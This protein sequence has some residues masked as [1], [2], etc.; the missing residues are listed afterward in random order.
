[1]AFRLTLT[2]R[3]E[4]PVRMLF[5]Q[6]HVTVG[7]APSNDVVVRDPKVSKAHAVIEQMPTGHHQLHDRD[8]KN[9]TFVEDEQ[10]GP[11]A[12]VVLS[13]GASVHMG[14]SMLSYMPL[15]PV[16]AATRNTEAA[17]HSDAEDASATER[18]PDDPKALF[19]VIERSLV[20][21]A[22]HIS[23][24]NSGNRDTSHDRHDEIKKRIA[25]FPESATDALVT[26]ARLSEDGM[27]EIDNVSSRSEAWGAL[28]A[29]LRDILALPAA[30]WVHLD[31]VPPAAERPLLEE[32]T[33]AEVEA[34][35]QANDESASLDRLCT[36][37]QHV[38]AHHRA[39]L[40]SYQSSI[41][42]G[43]KALL[44]HIS[45]HESLPDPSKTGVFTR[46]FGGGDTGVS[47]ER[48]ERRWRKLYHSDWED[49]E[50]KLFR[51]ALLEAYQEHMHASVPARLMP[52][53][54]EQADHSIPR[55]GEPT[56]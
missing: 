40:Q 22:S 46:V 3:D 4:P 20:R 29:T 6:D 43:G 8:S 19:D 1:M 13:P 7:R 15:I 37:L 26:L 44:R 55:P 17:P 39:M 14:D 2:V 9:A 45:P 47:W 5:D 10:V 33:T 25:T 24:G 12:P 52:E 41:K 32:P 16:T 35:L 53:A 11:E 49:I 18:L 38:V 50:A 31:E 27:P 51:P 23:S 42:T 21:L 54:A 36:A 30:L 56:S 28:P 34:A 48:L